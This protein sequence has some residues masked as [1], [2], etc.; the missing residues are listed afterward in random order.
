[1]LQNF[2]KSSQKSK[3][4]L[5]TKSTERQEQIENADLY[6]PI[7]NQKMTTQEKQ[8]VKYNFLAPLD[9]SY[10]ICLFKRFVNSY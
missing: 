3:Q 5:N 8:C 4:A 10:K 2:M 6:K 9:W 7:L 1:M